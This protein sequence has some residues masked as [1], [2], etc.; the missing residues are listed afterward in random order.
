MPCE[1]PRNCPAAL[2]RGVGSKPLVV[3]QRCKVG[4]STWTSIRHVF[5]DNRRT[6]WREQP[7]KEQLAFLPKNLP[8]S[9]TIFLEA[10]K[11]F[12]ISYQKHTAPAPPAP[13]AP[14]SSWSR[15]HSQSRPSSWSSSVMRLNVS[16]LKAH[17]AHTRVT[18]SHKKICF[19]SKLLT[20]SWKPT[21]KSQ[22][23]LVKSP[24]ST[25]NQRF[26]TQWLS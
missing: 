8:I 23:P 19:T 20:T 17:A 4:R 5:A 3:I 10:S 12:K 22:L 9:C 13:L 16:M 15:L 24:N 6:W 1:S 18:V 2:K 7:N 11:A 21:T 14:A 26:M 25:R